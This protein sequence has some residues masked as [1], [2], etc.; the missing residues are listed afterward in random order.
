LGDSPPEKRGGVYAH[1]APQPMVLSP[2]IEM[3]LLFRV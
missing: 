3:D 2:K 1:A